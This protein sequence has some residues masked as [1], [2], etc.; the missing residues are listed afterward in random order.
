MGSGPHPV[1]LLLLRFYPCTAFLAE[2]GP[3]FHRSAALRAD[4]PS[5]FPLHSTGVLRP[6][7][8]YR[9]TSPPQT[10]FLTLA[11]Q[12]GSLVPGTPVVQQPVA[13]GD[14]A[15]EWAIR[16]QPGGS[17][18]LENAGTGLVL[19]LFAGLAD[20]GG[21]VQG[22]LANGSQAQRW[23]I[24]QTIDPATTI[25]E[26][27]RENA[28]ALEDGTYVVSSSAGAGLALD[29]LAALPDDCANVQ[30]YEANG[31][32]AQ[33]WVVS[34][35]KTGYVTLVN[36]GSGKA[37]DV[38]GASKAPG[39]NV[40]QYQPNDSTAQK[41]VAVPQEGDGVVLVSALSPTICLEV[42]GDAPVS[43]SNVRVGARS[44]SANQVFEFSKVD[45]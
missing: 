1:R 14:L 42:E 21:S 15:Q 2:S 9:H 27:A 44:G 8:R 36:E 34:H 25:D 37:L 19:D 45:A 35:D 10:N 40:W 41:W 20:N 33:R 43:G 38:A 16:E 17:Y 7:A 39:T 24:S 31:T 12:G 32:A 3:S 18:V 26:W 5:A 4:D 11:V 6:I 30:V 22:Y 28:D 13:E 29:V 23:V